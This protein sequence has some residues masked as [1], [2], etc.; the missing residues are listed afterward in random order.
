VS[1]DGSFTV[2]QQEDDLSTSTVSPLTFTCSQNKNQLLSIHNEQLL[3]PGSQ[4]AVESHRRVLGKL[5][6]FTLFSA[7]IYERNG[8]C[9]HKRISLHVGFFYV[10]TRWYL[11]MYA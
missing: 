2:C 6:V 5:P 7:C 3:F 11:L 1:F 9:V 10:Y 4:T 8:V